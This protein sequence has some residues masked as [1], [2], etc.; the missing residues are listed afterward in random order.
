MDDGVRFGRQMA[1][2]GVQLRL[3]P[4]ATVAEALIQS[5]FGSYQLTQAGEVVSGRE[6]LWLTHTEADQ[7]FFQAGKPAGTFRLDYPFPPLYLATLPQARLVGEG[8]VVISGDNYLLAD[9]FSGEVALQQG[10][11]FLRQQLKIRLDDQ[12]HYLPFALH[13]DRGVSRVVG[14]PALLLSHYWHFNYHHWLVEC[15]PR[16]RYAFEWGELADCW[17]VVPGRMSPFQRDSLQLLGLDSRR[18]LPF[19]G[20]TWR[21]EQLY[22]PSIGVFSPVELGWLRQRLYRPKGGATRRLY[23]SRRDAQTRRLWNEE[24]LW[25]ILGR[26]GFEVLTLT[27]RTVAEQLELFATASHIM[28]P[29]G[30]GLTN[31]LFAPAGATL[32]ELTPNDQINHCF[33]LLANSNQ[34]RYTFL[35]GP[36]VNQNR[37]FTIAPAQ[38]DQLLR[39]IK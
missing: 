10:G 24:A 8:Y 3:L 20:Q 14:E 1:Q 35:T 26:H 15:L 21:F 16:L 6:P 31:L 34:H 38:L 5:P 13:R 33:W 11:H 19:D 39:K 37:D 30:A 25:P 17:V 29:H 28:G 2:N 23:I 4:I 9:S 22:F 18:L 12:D 32:I 7:H 36:I 27:G